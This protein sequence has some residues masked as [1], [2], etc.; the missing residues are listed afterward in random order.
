MVVL[1]IAYYTVPGAQP[2]ALVTTGLAGTAA[3]FAGVR[4]YRTDRWLA[5]TLL[6][7]SALLMTAG[8]LAYAVLHAWPGREVVYPDVPDVFFVS[9]YVPL[10][11][12]LILLGRPRAP[13]RDWLLALDTIAVGLAA[14]LLVW[15][16]L[17]RP[18]VISLHLTGMAKITAIASNVGY[19]AVL[20]SAALVAVAWRANAA[21]RVLG[22]ALASFLVSDYLYGIRIIEGTWRSGGVADLG[23][24]LFFAL[25]GMAALMPSMSAV[26]SPGHARNQLGAG[27]ITMVAIGLLVAPTVLL[28]AAT[29]GPVRTGVAIGLTAASIAIVIIARIALSTVAY[30]QKVLREKS[31][32]TAS[33]A[34]MLAPDE[35]AVVSGVATAL[36]DLVPGEPTGVTV[37]RPGEPVAGGLAMDLSEGEPPAELGKIVFHGPPAALAELTPTLRALADQAASAFERVSAVATLA[38]K[39][40]ERY[41]RTL[42]MTSTD[43]IMICKEGVIT[44]AT[45]SAA[46]LFGTDVVGSEFDALVTRTGPYG[47][48]PDVVDA[49]EGEIDRPDG[50]VAVL[51]H[52]RDLYGDPTVAGVV[53]TLRDITAERDLR[54]DL[55][56][57]ASHDVVTGL[58][59]PQLF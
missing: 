59:N 19:A 32:R 41:F 56:H 17:V 5:W 10:A 51:V 33:R 28:V 4:A 47:G 21:L 39:E 7:V 24:L 40:R 15:I 6:G 54:R 12:G 13:A 20:A 52:R 48:W 50:T 43:V 22:V 8:E 26:A 18:A 37:L 27:R 38:A 46:A 57:R 35:A 1:I 2:F 58:G 3:I 16:T 44:Y 30:K 14:T 34:L 25:C 55:A 42:V 36:R 11:L 9:A 29:S 53:T 49:E 45:P 23:F 31:L